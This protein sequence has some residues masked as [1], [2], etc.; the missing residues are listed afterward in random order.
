MSITVKPGRNPH[1]ARAFEALREAE[2][3]EKKRKPEPTPEPA[4][5]AKP[6]RAKG[7]KPSKRKS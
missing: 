6:P 1:V 5:N 7:G 4:K 3:A 2:R